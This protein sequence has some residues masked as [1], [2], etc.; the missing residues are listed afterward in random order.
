MLHT[1]KEKKCIIYKL[2]SPKGSDHIGHLGVWET[3]IKLLL[4][5][6]CKE[7]DSIRHGRQL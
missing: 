5:K 3:D 7:V 6:L 4:E 2:V 1:R